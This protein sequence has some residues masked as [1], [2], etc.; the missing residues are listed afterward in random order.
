MSSLLSLDGLEEL[1][2]FG[3]NGFEVSLV[4]GMSRRRRRH[5][6]MRWGRLYGGEE[7]EEGFCVRGG[8]KT[9]ETE[10]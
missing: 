4:L 10:R 1:N 6:G 5:G 7:S 3:N 2:T 8:R 9:A